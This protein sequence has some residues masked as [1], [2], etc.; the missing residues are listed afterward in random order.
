VRLADHEQRWSGD[1]G[2]DNSPDDHSGH[3]DRVRANGAGRRRNRTYISADTGPPGHRQPGRPAAHAASQLLISHAVASDTWIESDRLQ[4]DLANPTEIDY[5][6]TR[7]ELS[8]TEKRFSLSFSRSCQFA[9]VAFSERS[10]S[11]E[12]KSSG[13][14]MTVVP[15]APPD[16][17]VLDQKSQALAM[18]LSS[19]KVIALWVQLFTLDASGTTAWKVIALGSRPDAHP[20]AVIHAIIRTFGDTIE[21]SKMQ[22]ASIALVDG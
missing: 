21:P 8:A 5:S 6:K 1:D 3:R 10:L 22:S 17:A 13:I 20:G 18:T 12:A 9:E 2:V 15:T 14:E 16:L 4:T 11:P 19:M 7:Q